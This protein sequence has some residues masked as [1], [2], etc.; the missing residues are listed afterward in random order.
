M[1]KFKFDIEKKNLSWEK[2]L[3]KTCDS[4]KCK[5]KGEFKAPKSRIRLNE[6][7]FFCLKH[8]K[9]YNKSWDFYK[10]LTVDQ[11][12]KS[13]RNDTV[14]DRPSWP[15][16]GN[17]NNVMEQINQFMN[18]DF[19]SFDHEKLSNSFFK[20]KLIDET[21]T[22]DQNNA[23]KLLDLKLPLSID[24]IKKKYKKLVKIFH[25]DVNGNNKNAENRF[26]EINVSYKL[27]LKKFV[28]KNEQN[29]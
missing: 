13:M 15:L 1:N 11:M 17:P 7:Y 3:T 18:E 29:I 22:K 8:I 19:A 2:S 24:K 16:K 9:E 10:G 23:L 25:P 27:L 28:K 14:W 20:N 5:E 21:L 6:Y 26:K 12:E 4:S